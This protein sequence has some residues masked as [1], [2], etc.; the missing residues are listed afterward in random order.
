M[1]F[2][3]PLAHIVRPSLW[4]RPPFTRAGHLYLRSLY[5]HSDG[6]QTGVRNLEYLSAR[7]FY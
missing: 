4:K 6:I 3:L 1:C 2:T 7:R 5:C